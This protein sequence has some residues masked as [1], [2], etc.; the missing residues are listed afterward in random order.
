VRKLQKSRL[1]YGIGYRTLLAQGGPSRLS[2]NGISSNSAAY[3]Y[4]VYEHELIHIYFPHLYID[5]TSPRSDRTVEV[6]YMIPALC[7][8]NTLL[9]DCQGL[10]E[11]GV[12]DDNRTDAIEI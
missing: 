8:A 11:I 10:L 2:M 3:I 7:D 1:V 5:L 9:V 12:H 4:V 6:N